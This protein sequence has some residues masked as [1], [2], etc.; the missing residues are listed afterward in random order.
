MEFV[1]QYMGLVNAYNSM[2]Q[3]EKEAV[4]TAFVQYRAE[5][6]QWVVRFVGEPRD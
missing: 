1:R 6:E 5:Q 2:S 4:T 3:D